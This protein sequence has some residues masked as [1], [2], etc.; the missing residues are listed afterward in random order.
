MRWGGGVRGSEGAFKVSVGG[1]LVIEGRPG[2]SWGAVGVAGVGMGDW[3]KGAAG[4]GGVQGRWERGDW[5]R[6]GEQGRVWGTGHR[7]A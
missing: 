2:R 6:G 1:L 3:A 4:Q 5:Q 7:S